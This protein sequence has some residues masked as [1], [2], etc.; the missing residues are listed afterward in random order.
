MFPP[1]LLFRQINLFAQERKMQCIVARN[2][3]N[4][5]EQDMAYCNN[6]ALTMLRVDVFTQQ[7]NMK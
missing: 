7:E 1:I 3:K 2:K 5:V 4:D 6:I